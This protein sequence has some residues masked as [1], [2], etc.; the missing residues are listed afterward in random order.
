[1]GGSG[2]GESISKSQNLLSMFRTCETRRPE[3]SSLGKGAG[4][5]L[6]YDREAAGD[7]LLR[8]D[9]SSRGADR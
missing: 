6:S 8:K 5:N 9:E 1:M 2:E 3:N 4:E 7:L